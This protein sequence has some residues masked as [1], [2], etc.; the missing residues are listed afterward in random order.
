MIL[1]K[2]NVLAQ[3][4]KDR[5]VHHDSDLHQHL[6]PKYEYI[7]GTHTAFTDIDKAVARIQK[8]IHHQ[9][10]ICVYG[11]FDV[12]GLT[13]TAIL[14]KTIKAKGGIAFPYIPNRITQGHSLHRS[15]IQRIAEDASLI[16][17]VDCG[18]NAVSEVEYANY[19]GCNVII[20]DH[21][22]AGEILPSAHAV[23]VPPAKLYTDFSGAGIAFK[24]AQALLGDEAKDLLGLAAIGTI[25]DLVPQHYENRMISYLGLQQL[26]KDA[27]YGLSIM[28]ERLDRQDI[29]T[30]AIRYI[31]APRL[32]SASRFGQAD[33]AFNLLMTDQKDMAVDYCEQLEDLNTQRKS[34]V[35]F[36]MQLADIDVD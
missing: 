36:L 19:L 17:T 26:N 35:D 5:G 9:E 28:L 21:H 4:L 18:I 24:P 8:A 33:I 27:G 12:D 11:D 30:N 31:L 14:L 32:N 25:T 23:I 1:S 15:A 22:P 16:I 20:T 2:D 10:M 7:D 29:T 34:E 6:N 3:I 13:S